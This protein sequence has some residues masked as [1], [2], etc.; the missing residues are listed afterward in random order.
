MID[1]LLYVLCQHFRFIDCLG[2]SYN[3]VKI[4]NIGGPVFCCKTHIIIICVL[5]CQGGVLKEGI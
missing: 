4:H 3:D 1:Y 5:Y 2:E